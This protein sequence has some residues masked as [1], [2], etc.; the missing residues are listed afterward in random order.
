MATRVC[1]PGSELSRCEQHCREDYDAEHQISGGL[2]GLCFRFA[3]PYDGF[4]PNA[5]AC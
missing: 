1:G 2:V 3:G 5:E 4:H